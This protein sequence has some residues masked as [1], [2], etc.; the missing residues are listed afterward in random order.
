M[1][2]KIA[3]ALP[4]LQ[5]RLPASSEADLLA[6]TMALGGLPLALE[7][8]C[9]YINETGIGIGSYLQRL[10]EPLRAWELLDKTA[11]QLCSR[12]VF[13]TLTLGL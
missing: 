10:Q 3:E 6:L 7:Q 13:V 11:S 2:G 8:A 5:Q 4:F 9:A 1:F 12:S